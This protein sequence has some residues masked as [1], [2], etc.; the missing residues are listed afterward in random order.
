[1]I[2]HTPEYDDIL[3]ICLDAVLAGEWTIVA[4]L[5]TYPEHAHLLRPALQ[6]ALLAYNLQ[7]TEMPEDR[8]MALEM[9]LRGQMLADK[10]TQPTVTDMR[11]RPVRP[12]PFAP[13]AKLAA[14]IAIVF[15]FTLA[16]GSGAVAASA[17]SLPGD[18]LYEFKRLWEG[19]VL[20]L[21]SLGDNSDDIWLHLAK[22]RLNEAEDLAEQRGILPSVVFV[23]LY[24]TTT[25]AITLA[26]D[27][28]TPLVVLFLGRAE[29]RLRKIPVTATTEPLQHDLLALMIQQVDAGGRLS[30]P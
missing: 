26:D 16:A 29:V 6:T 1:M 10:Q 12:S 30:A 15:L 22:T 3:D 18:S 25:Q 28:T 19:I 20:S 9:R 27:E 2:D 11:P 23:D 17:T 24:E 14:M 21:S 13:L 8:V 5:E 7:T 4:C